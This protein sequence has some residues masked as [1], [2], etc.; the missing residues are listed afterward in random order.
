MSKLAVTIEEQT[1][2]IEVDLSQAN[3]NEMVVKVDG[4][5]VHVRMPDREAPVEQMEWIVVDDKP[6]EIVLDRDLSWI[7]SQSRNFKLEVRNRQDAVTRPQ[8][9][10]SRV[11]APIPGQITQVFV[12][13]GQAVNAGQPLM[14]LEAMKMENEIRSPRSG[15]VYAVHV[16]AGAT[17]SLHQVLVEIG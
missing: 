3:E 16:A 7:H 13:P 17:V 2:E 12:A 8:S 4:Q 15:T 9:R 14:M 6:Y 11:K 10:D 1:F 5:P